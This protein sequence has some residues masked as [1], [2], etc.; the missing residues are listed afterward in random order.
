MLR[1]L[2]VRDLALVERA[3]LEL[4]PGLCVLTGET[5]AGKSLLVAAMA[6]LRGGRASADLV[7]QGA[8]VAVVEGV[9]DGEVVER[10]R[11]P[12]EAAGVVAGEELILRRQVSRDGRSRAVVNDQVVTL[13]TLRELGTALIDLHGQH[14][15]QVLLDESQHARLLDEAAGLAGAAGAVR[16]ARSALRSACA[17]LAEAAAERERI[18][19]TAADLTAIAAEVA[20]LD[21][22]PAKDEIETLRTER[23]ALRHRDKIIEGLRNAGHLLAEDEGA[24]LERVGI[25]E[26][27][28]RTLEALDPS[29]VPAREQLF[30]ARLL[31][32]EVARAA[33]R[34]LAE[35]DR[36]PDRLVAVEDRLASLERLV[37]RHGSLEGARAAAD[38]ARRDLARLE[39]RAEDEER[40]RVAEATRALEG[41]ARDL[42]AARAKA[43]ARLAKSVAAELRTLGFPG[44]AFEIA[45]E[46][47]KGGADLLDAISD[48]GRET[49]R[50]LLAPNP[51]EGL[52]ALG[53]TAAGGELSRVMLALRTALRGG[54]GAQVL[55]FDEVDHGVGGIV[56]DAVADR[57]AALAQADRQVLCVTHQ[58]RIAARARLHVHVDKQ[59]RGGRTSTRFTPL[60]RRGR[61][62]EL[63]RLLA[64]RE[65]GP[66]AAALAEELLARHEPATLLGPP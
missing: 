23:E 30:E 9:F 31:I 19:R 59:T 39:D 26:G 44:G 45:L 51:G 58:A 21:P 33:E 32:E 28:L 22:D 5:G 13:A 1:Q 25:V 12:L 48:E 42:S 54:G 18:S 66:R 56:L 63:E 17:R 62:R 43:G 27:W 34:R 35:L 8:E 11:T 50:F 14:E 15:H 6:A 49:V 24:A 10:L 52:H 65:P 2:S 46:P 38:A 55:V 64:G 40:E 61:L 16:M 3:R 4:V 60:D 47:R 57:L 37:R 29:L 41:A 7:R 53:K 20:E 36:E